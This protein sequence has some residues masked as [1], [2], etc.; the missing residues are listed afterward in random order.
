M[1]SA[2]IRLLTFLVPLSLVLGCGKP[3]LPGEDEIGES[4]DT[5]S[6]STESESTES[7]STESESTESESTE[8]ES[9][10]TESDSTDG[11]SIDGDSAESTESDT[12]ES[13][14]NDVDTTESESTESETTDVD[15]TDVDTADFDTT[16]VD[17]LDFDTTD[18]DGFENGASCTA[19][20]ECFSGHCYV[21]PFLGGQC[22]ECNE[23]ADC[24]DGGC[25]AP[26]PFES[27][28]S[29]CNQG[30]LAGGCE[31][32]AVCQ[33]ELVCQ[34]VFNLLDLIVIQSCGECAIDADCEPGL[35]CAPLVELPEWSGAKQCIA[36]ASLP[37]DSYCDLEGNGDE[38]CASG[39]CSTV[40]V[41]GLDEIGSCGE[42]K[43][44]AD[45]NGGIC[46]PGELILDSNTLVGSSCQ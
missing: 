43:T 3:D 36:A 11:D 27:I 19:D 22:G 42:C 6:E 5:E 1:N 35:I 32:D 4:G 2:Q 46:T 9:D 25:T 41:Q 16:D 38:A 17:T 8:S 14:T 45:C 34:Q 20:T 15:T 37:Q 10:S 23:D 26:N 29:V 28:G 30:E 12:T 31:S 13:D 40:D 24:P 44:D 7:E 33:P 21:I 39:M 18:T